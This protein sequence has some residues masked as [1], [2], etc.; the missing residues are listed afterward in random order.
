MSK[1]FQRVIGVVILLGAGALSL[2]VTASFLDGPGTENWILPVQASLMAVIGAA[3]GLALPA[4]APTGAFTAVRALIGA[5]WGL[6]AGM[7]GLLT[8]WFL[9]NGLGGA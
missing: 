4:L 1:T 7:V 6:L 3:C 2:P 9:L 5:G 8:F